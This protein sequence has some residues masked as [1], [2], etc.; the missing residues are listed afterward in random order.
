[1]DEA[2]KIAEKLGDYYYGD[3]STS[4]HNEHRV[5]T[6]LTLWYITVELNIAPC[7]PIIH[8]YKIVAGSID[9]AIE[10]VKQHF[11][12]NPPMFPVLSITAGREELIQPGIIDIKTLNPTGQY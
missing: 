7:K 11:E 9:R 10:I 5:L 12:E 3:I 6:P 2:V 8:E 4:I 1:M